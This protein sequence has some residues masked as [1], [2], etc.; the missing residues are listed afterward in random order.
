MSTTARPQQPYRGTHRRPTGD[1]A[2]LPAPPDDH[3][4][5]LYA[6][7][8][9]P[10]LAI[11]L[12]ICFLAGTASQLWFEAKSGMW[13]F[14]I[15][16]AITVLSFGL[17]LPLCFCGRG[18][19]VAAHV[20]RVWAWRPGRYPEVDIYLPICAEPI[21]VLRNTWTAVFEL[22]HAYPGLARPYVLDDG[23]DP[24]AERLASDFGFTYV[25]RPDPGW[26]KKSGNLR[27]AFARTFGEFIVILDAD[28]APRA[29][30]LAETLPYFDDAGV[31]IVQTPQYFR[32]HGGQTWIER[33][34][35]AAQEIFYR[36]V[37]V[38]RDRLGAAICV[39]S[40][41]VY[42]RAA[43]APEG[44][45]TLIPFAED[46]HT[47]LDACGNGWR[48][49][50]LP[51]VLAT[52]I[53]PSSLDMFV[54]QQY[55]WCMGATSTVLTRRLWVVPMTARAR[56]AYLSGFA[57]YV[58]T[59]LSVFVIPLIPICLLTWQPLTVR[60]ENSRLVVMTVLAGFFLLPV[61]ATS[62]FNLRDVVPLMEARGWAHALALW[63]W[64]RG[65]PM[66]WRPT[67]G[68]VSQV[69]RFRIGA[70]AWNGGAA[71]A[72]LALAAWRTVEARSWQFAIVIILG[73]CY[74]AGVCRLLRAL[75]GA[76]A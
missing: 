12:V 2:A 34:A 19:D 30:F 66:A 27:Y 54:R 56:L 3:E 26:Y 13:P 25:V 28:F 8:N 39:G 49:S 71:T 67:G 46:V 4:K 44:G 59:A 58:Q 23:P 24:A 60:V 5:Y 55:R 18:F 70:V 42:R 61:W 64:L 52:G 35:G 9:L 31:A 38:A 29:D 45:P 32:T 14:A 1:P 50:Y 68:R 11:V 75:G 74:A 73:L 7:R 40:C 36:A 72:W 47:G 20:R 65:R 6:E 43:L 10:Y 57:H 62:T 37:Q 21:D 69:R 15:F 16:T 76:R 51:V 17:A 33:A 63:D 53:C 22:C 48:V 41:A